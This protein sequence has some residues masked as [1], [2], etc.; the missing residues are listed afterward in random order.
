LDEAGILRKIREKLDAGTLSRQPPLQTWG[1]L[2]GGDI[3]AVC[4]ERISPE[5]VEV[6][7]DD[8]DGQQSFYHPACYNHL[9]AEWR[10]LA[11]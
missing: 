5:D 7:A 4:D 6:Q 8:A 3:C 9:V 1:S 2:T 11:E 10:R